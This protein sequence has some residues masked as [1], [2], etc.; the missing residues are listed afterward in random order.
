M[1]IIIIIVDNDDGGALSFAPRSIL[2][3][4]ALILDTMLIY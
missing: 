1:M 2:T 3:F 4:V